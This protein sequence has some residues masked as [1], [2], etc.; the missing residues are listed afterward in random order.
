LN[1]KEEKKMIDNPH[2]FDI[3]NSSVRSADFLCQNSL[4]VC[5]DEHTVLLTD[6]RNGAFLLEGEMDRFIDIKGKRFGRL[7]VLKKVVS[8]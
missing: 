5:V 7:V 1:K 4:R 3:I 2:T 6:R 8:N